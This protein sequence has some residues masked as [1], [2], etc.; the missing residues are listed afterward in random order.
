LG[1]R[2]VVIITI[3][4]IVSSMVIGIA[5]GLSYAEAILPQTY[6][7][8]TIS[9]IAAGL[10]VITLF[11]GLTKSVLDS[12]GRTQLEYSSISTRHYEQ[13]T[14]GGRYS[15]VDYRLELKNKGRG[16]E[17][18]ECK[19]TLTVTDTPIDRQY[20]LWDKGE[21]GIPIG[22]DELLKLFTVGEF[23]PDNKLD[24]KKVVFYNHEMEFIDLKVK[25]S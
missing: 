8:S 9:W 6:A 21:I 20:I 3:I 12:V 17:A 22:H 1:A 24:S 5:V 2:T 13:E 11:W 19:A 18:E 15:Y 7:V 10:G 25:L 16:I 14:N 23:Y 4:L